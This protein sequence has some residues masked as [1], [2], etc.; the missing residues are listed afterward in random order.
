MV[1]HSGDHHTLDSVTTLA[2]LRWAHGEHSTILLDGDD[3]GTSETH[4]VASQGPFDSE[5]SQYEL[6]IRKSGGL[7]P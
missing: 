1:V 6:K 5:D 4:Y 7:D 3:T 2:S